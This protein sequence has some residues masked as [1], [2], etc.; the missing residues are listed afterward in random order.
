MIKKTWLV[1]AMLLV[2]TSVWAAKTWDVSATTHNLGSTATA[3]TYFVYVATNEDEVCIFCHTPHGGTLNTPLWNRTLPNQGAGSEFSHYTSTTLSTKIRVD[4]SPTRPIS[5]E[6]LLCMSCHDGVVGV[7]TLVNYSNGTV[8]KPDNELAK[9]QPM[10][11]I[12][13]GS[14]IGDSFANDRPT[15]DLRDDHPI[16]FSYDAVKADVAKGGRLHTVAEAKNGILGVRF[17]GT[18]NRVECSS[19]HDPHVN[20]NIDSAYSPFLVMPNTGSALCLACHIK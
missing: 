12:T 14:A 15:R 7:G 13:P 20:G 11:P 5:A 17:F 9:I 1:V 10:L 4:L 6:S 16:S 8:G 3:A 19:C 2:T 18:N